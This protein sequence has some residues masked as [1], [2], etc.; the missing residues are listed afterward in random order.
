VTS[1]V[2]KGTDRSDVE[3]RK[4]SLARKCETCGAPPGEPCVT[5]RKGIEPRPRNAPHPARIA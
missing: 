5:V 1:Y 2:Y 4:P 3:R